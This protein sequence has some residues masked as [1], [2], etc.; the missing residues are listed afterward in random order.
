[1]SMAL[2][3]HVPPDA[4]PDVVNV[5]FHVLTTSVRTPISPN[6]L[7]SRVA[8][9]LGKQPRGE[10]LALLRDLEILTQSQGGLVLTPSGDAVASSAE[11]TD[12]IHGLSYI[13]WSAA[14]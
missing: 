12:L 13:S 2:T 6:E 9:A 3:F 10:A 11:S 5:I 8:D 1:M 14:D 4:S 7:K